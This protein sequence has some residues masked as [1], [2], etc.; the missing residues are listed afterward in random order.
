MLGAFFTGFM[1]CFS[2]N[3]VIGAQNTYLFRQGIRNEYVYILATFCTI[4]DFILILAGVYGMS[5]IVNQF[6]TDLFL[7]LSALTL[8]IYGV[9]RVKKLISLSY[10]VSKEDFLEKSLKKSLLAMVAFTLLNPH[11]YLDT[12]ILIGS[13]SLQ[14]NVHDKIY[15]IIGATFASIIFFY[16]VAVFSKMFSSFSNNVLVLKVVDLIT[17]GILFIISFAMIKATSFM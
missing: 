16:G 4:C 11:V 9:L 8:I 10:G 12:V 7:I 14:Y 1:L 2:L 3:C 5:L 6:Y 13:A 17:G 15:Y